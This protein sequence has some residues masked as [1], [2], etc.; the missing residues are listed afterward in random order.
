MTNL[1]A[2]EVRGLIMP[3][4]KKYQAAR[5]SR[6]Q[7]SHTLVN[8]VS[9][10]VLTLAE[11]AAYLRLQEEEVVRLVHSQGLPGRSTSSEWRFLK[12]AI[13]DWLATAS[14][15]WETRKLGIL[16]LAGK[17]KEDPDLEPIVKEAYR[18]RG[19]SVTEENSRE[20]LAD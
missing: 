5:R 4:I 11:A 15:N 20:N 7:Q 8:G 17:Y 12:A 9:D 13:Q 1:F 2:G 10:D 6:S 16:E 19:R 3:R 14:P 18:Q